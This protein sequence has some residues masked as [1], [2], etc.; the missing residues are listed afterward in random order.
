MVAFKVLFIGVLL[1]LV[2]ATFNLIPIPP[3]DGSKIVMGLLSRELAVKYEGL[4][5]YGMILFVIL[6][7]TRVAGY[8]IWPPVLLG[9]HF[10]GFDL[11]LLNLL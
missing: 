9:L 10:L 2:L 5:R 7:V 8:I 3:L 4:G 1:N 11:N 6:I